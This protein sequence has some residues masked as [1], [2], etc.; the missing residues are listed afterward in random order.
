MTLIAPYPGNYSYYAGLILV[1]IYGYTFFKLRF[2]WATVAGWMIVIAYE[3][4]A[5]WLSEAPTAVLLNNNFFFLAGN[6]IGMFSCYSTEFYSRKDFIQARLLEGE[7]KKVK[8]SNRE[9]EKR[10]EERTAQ[11]MNTNEELREEVNERKCAEEAMRKAK[12]EAEMANVAKSE[13]LANMSHE[14]RTPMN[15]VIG[16]ADMLLDSNLDENQVDCARTLK[17]SGEGLLSLLNDILDFSKIEA[18]ELAF[19]EVDFDPEILAYD[20]CELIRPKIGSKPI[21]ILC[22]IGEKIPAKVKGDPLRFRQVLTNLMDNA[23]KFTESGEIE[24]YLGIEEVKDNRVR[25][26]AAIRDTGIGISKEHLASILK[27]FQQGDGSTTRKYG[28]TG[29]GLSISKQI[30]YIM[31]GDVWAESEVGIGSVFHFTSWLRKAEQEQAKRFAPLTLSGKKVLIVDDNQANLDIMTHMLES[32]GMRVVALRNSEEVVSALKKAKEADNPFDICILDIQMP[33]MSGYD[34]AMHIRDPKYP[35]TNIPL[36]ALSS[37]M[38]RDSKKCQELGIDGFLNKPVRGEKLYQMLERCAGEGQYEGEGDKVVRE[39]IRTQDTVQ[40]DR[41]HSVNILLAEDNP[42]NQK[43]A[44]MMLTNAGY[45]VEVADDGKEAVEKYT[46]SPKDFDL[47]FMDVQMPKMD[48]MEAT[49]AIRKNGSDSIPIVAM[50]AHA[51]KG[52]REKCLEVGMDDYITKP[53]KKDLVL[54]VLEKWV[55]KKRLLKVIVE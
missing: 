22:R 16:F 19:E 6:I 44:K 50:T 55:I 38:E 26:H 42:V 40:E 32:V 47:I 24:L 30:S 33:T 34:L 4:A 10:V 43:L 49:K 2:I 45:H 20:V 39:K 37:G 5:V 31:D 12:A 21:E 35:F 7:K 15:A 29:L 53:I 28:G 52:D 11:L 48:G 17:T 41:K 23:S 27:P 3:C 36:I 14:I 54:D 13:F 18:G 1:F 46:K 9:L 51:M 25:L 8:A